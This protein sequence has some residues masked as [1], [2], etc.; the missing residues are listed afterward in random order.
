MRSKM[1]FS[2]AAAVRQKT[3]SEATPVVAVG[4]MIPFIKGYGPVIFL[5]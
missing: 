4:G 2:D 5:R 3:R 1:D